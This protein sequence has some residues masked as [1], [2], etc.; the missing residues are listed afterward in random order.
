MA[1]LEDTGK[2]QDFAVGLLAVSSHQGGMLSWHHSP[3][4]KVSEQPNGFVVAPDQATHLYL[5]N[6]L[7][8]KAGRASRVPIL[9]QFT[10]HTAIFIRIKGKID[11][12]RGFVPNGFLRGLI[13]DWELP[14][15]GML[16]EFFKMIKP[17]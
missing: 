4:R 12:V 17:C 14:S 13:P 5:M 2:K 11:F 6:N 3:S 16:A 15:R 8:D 7:G 9:D 1:Y 10:G